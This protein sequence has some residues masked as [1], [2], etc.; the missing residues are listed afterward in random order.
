[1]KSILM[2]ITGIVATIVRCRTLKAV[3]GCVSLLW[4]RRTPA[5]KIP[6]KMPSKMAKQKRHQHQI[7]ELSELEPGKVYAFVH[8]RKCDGRTFVYP[9]RF[10]GNFYRTPTDMGLASIKAPDRDGHDKFTIHFDGWSPHDNFEKGVTRFWYWQ[11]EHPSSYCGP[12]YALGRGADAEHNEL[13][14]PLD[15]WDES[16]KVHADWGEVVHR[17]EEND[18]N[19]KVWVR[20]SV[21]DRKRVGGVMT[22]LAEGATEGAGEPVY[23]VTFPNPNGHL[24]ATLFGLSEMES[25][26]GWESVDDEQDR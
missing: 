19:K 11:G 24:G 21:G 22:Q 14:V 8:T 16:P 20:Q 15:R 6:A 10:A 18:I 12:D 25:R 17:P 9:R 2:F 1:M 26:Q 23:Y 3:S 5:A 7:M 13:I 4:H